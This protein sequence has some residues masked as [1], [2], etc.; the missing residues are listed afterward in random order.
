MRGVLNF[1]VSVYTR[2][3]KSIVEKINMVPITTYPITPFN[4]EYFTFKEFD[5]PCQKGSG[6]SMDKDF[7]IQL[8]TARAIAGIPFKI[9]SG[10][11]TKEHNKKVGGVAQSSH[12]KGLAADISIPNSTNRFI[13]ISALLEVGITRIGVGKNFL[14]CDCDKEKSQ[15]VMWTYY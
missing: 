11:R 4:M 2:I 5:C 15:S 8:D 7:L 6:R 12:L 13:V 1:L 14:H 10:Y 3:R 9:T